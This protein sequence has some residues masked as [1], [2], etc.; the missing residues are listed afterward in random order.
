MRRRSYRFWVYIMA[1]INHHVLYIGMTNDIARRMYEHVH[2][3]VEG[4]TSE[5]R[6]HKLVYF[7]EY[8]YVHDAIAREKQL[9]QFRREDKLKLIEESNP[10]WEDLALNLGVKA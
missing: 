2:G 3:V 4:F 7:E 5:F 6:V 1:N 8:Q 10:G 9:K